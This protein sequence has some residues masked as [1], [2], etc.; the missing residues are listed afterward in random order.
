[1]AELVKLKVAEGQRVIHGGSIL[2]EGEVFEVDPEN[3][4]SLVERG[5]ANKSAGRPK[6]SHS[7]TSEKPAETAKAA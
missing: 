5:I 1:M 6:V 4:E 2:T 7:E 3:A